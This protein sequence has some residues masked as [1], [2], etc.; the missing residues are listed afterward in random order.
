[1]GVIAA[2]AAI[3]IALLIP[4]VASATS[5]TGTTLNGTVGK[6]MTVP[7][8]SGPPFDVA[9][10]SSASP[11]VV[12]CGQLNGKAAAA[13]V[14]MWCLAPTAVGGVAVTVNYLPNG[15][16]APIP[17]TVLTVNCAAA[18]VKSIAV[19]NSHTM[20][21]LVGIS[22]VA[23]CNSNT[24][25]AGCTFAKKTISES[26][27]LA[28]TLNTLPVLVTA[29]VVVNGPSVINGKTVLVYFVCD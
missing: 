18:K 28:V 7:M 27:G 15:L 2:V 5:I 20:V 6:F 8:G 24:V 11:S 23:S 1:L 12:A 10:C 21:P 19:G 9:S 16:N 22:S 25:G 26:C 4:S 29:T 14:R 3:G 17:S 13:E